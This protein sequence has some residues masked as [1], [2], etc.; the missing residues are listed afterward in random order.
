MDRKEPIGIPG[1]QI[2][3]FV[4]KVGVKGFFSPFRIVQ[5]PHEHVPRGDN[6]LSKSILRHKRVGIEVMWTKWSNLV[7]IGDIVV[8]SEANF[9]DSAGP[10]PIGD[11]LRNTNIR[12]KYKTNAVQVFYESDWSYWVRTVPW[13]HKTPGSWSP[14]SQSTSEL[15][16][17]LEQHWMRLQMPDQGQELGAPYYN[18]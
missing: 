7:R 14:G 10:M 13:L 11:V 1:S 6:H 18:I 17:E 5:V 8:D 16:M 4:P 15:P 12:F 9:A 3:S 2:S